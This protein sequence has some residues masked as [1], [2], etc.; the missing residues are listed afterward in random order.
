LDAVKGKNTAIGA[1]PE[2]FVVGTSTL[3]R[4]PQLVDVFW[5]RDSDLEIRTLYVSLKAV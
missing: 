4:S 5:V 2:T 1:L 3:D